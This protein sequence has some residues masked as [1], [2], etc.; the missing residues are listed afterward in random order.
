MTDTVLLPKSRSKVTNGYIDGRSAEGRRF[1]DLAMSFAD[2]AGG[3]DQLSES[4]RVLIK[5]AV[6]LTMHSERLQGAQIR[7]EKVDIDQQLRVAE[8]L[9]LTIDRLFGRERAAARDAASA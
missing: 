9:S 1:R 7:G 5:T 4:Q 6:A 2:D 8:L 3:A